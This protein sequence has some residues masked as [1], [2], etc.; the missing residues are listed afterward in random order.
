[1][2]RQASRTPRRQALS[3]RSDLNQGESWA[4]PLVTSQD[5]IF[6][7]FALSAGTGTC[8]L[9][10]RRLRLDMIPL[11]ASS[12]SSYWHYGRTHCESPNRDPRA[13]SPA[14]MPYHPLYLGASCEHYEG[15]MVQATTLREL[16]DFRPAVEACAVTLPS[17]CDSMYETCE[18]YE[19]AAELLVHE[20]C[21][22]TRSCVSRPQYR[23][24]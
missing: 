7:P 11:L 19:C 6:L 3:R 17:W 18:R 12:Q 15:R 21:Q 14:S 5:T 8:S 20:A 10:N 1:M 13:A 2:P 4:V 9:T 24:S 23:G 16:Y 22:G